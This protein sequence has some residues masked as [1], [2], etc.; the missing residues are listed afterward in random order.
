M[1]ALRFE[2]MAFLLESITGFQTFRGRWSVPCGAHLRY[3]AGTEIVGMEDGTDYFL[4]STEEKRAGDEAWD[5]MRREWGWDEPG[6][7]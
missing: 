2:S 1:K 7:E 3:P 5:E 6:K 4:L